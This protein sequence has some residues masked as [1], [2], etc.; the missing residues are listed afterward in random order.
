MAKAAKELEKAITAHYWAEYMAAATDDRPGLRGKLMRFGANTGHQKTRASKIV[1]Q[2]GAGTGLALTMS[3][4]IAIIAGAP[5]VALPILGGALAIG[6]PLQA[7]STTGKS[8]ARRAVK[9]AIRRDIENGSL[10]A[11]YGA[12]VLQKQSRQKQQYLNEAAW[13]SGKPARMDDAAERKAYDEHMTKLTKEFHAACKAAGIPEGDVRG[14]ELG[15]LTKLGNDF[16][17]R[18]DAYIASRNGWSPFK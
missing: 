10:L 12:E 2:G 1:E 3:G 15:K 14:E 11:R 8:M 16:I 4:C 18:R 13:L 7:A 5:A 6:L 9:K 17:A